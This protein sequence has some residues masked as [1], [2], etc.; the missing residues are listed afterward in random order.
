MH[1][2]VTLVLKFL[3]YQW[4]TDKYLLFGNILRHFI[5]S[6]ESLYFQIS[7]SQ[8]LI[9]CQTHHS[10][11]MSISLCFFR[12]EHIY[13]SSYLCSLIKT[14]FLDFF[15]FWMINIMII[16]NSRCFTH[17]HQVSK[18]YIQGYISKK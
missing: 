16:N 7:V 13:L 9:W 3:S 14:F 6:D 12:F 4:F 11:L 18:L 10:W 15:F 5:N 1:L 17:V 8:I 2:N